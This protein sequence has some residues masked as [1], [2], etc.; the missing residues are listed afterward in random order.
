MVNFDLFTWKKLPSF[1]CESIFY[2]FQKDGQI[3]LV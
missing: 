1:M 2:F 3:E